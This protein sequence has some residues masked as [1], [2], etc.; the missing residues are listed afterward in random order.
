MEEISGAI[1]INKPI[2]FIRIRSPP[3]DAFYCSNKLRS[4]ELINFAETDTSMKFTSRFS[5]VTLLIA[6]PIYRKVYQKVN[7]KVYHRCSAR[8]DWNNL[9]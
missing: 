6:L 8:L 2:N 5:E 4:F 9:R 1:L 3:F 7:Q